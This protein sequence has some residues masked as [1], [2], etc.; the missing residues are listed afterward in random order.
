MS[1]SYTSSESQS[2]TITHARKIAVKVATDLKRMQRFYGYPS[3]SAIQGYEEEIVQ[4]LK[5]GYLKKVSYGF[6]K[7]DEWIEPSLHFE[8]KDL[9]GFTST[10]DDPGRIKPGAD[11]SGASFYSYLTYNNEWWK[12]TSAERETFE[13][14]LPFQRGSANEPGVNGYLSQ[15]KTYAAGARAVVR[16]TVKSY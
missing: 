10:D 16:S 14:G 12:L 5:Q 7:N 1:S 9:G 15:D 4:F 11:I 6:Q 3:D 13:E 2:F 8:A